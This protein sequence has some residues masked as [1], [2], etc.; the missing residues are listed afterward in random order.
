VETA[1]FTATALA[2]V[3]AAPASKDDPSPWR[4]DS[5]P[6]DFKPELFEKGLPLKQEKGAIHVL[7]WATVA[8][9]YWQYEETKAIVV[10][11]FARPTVND[12][13][14]WLLA[15]LHHNQDPKR[16]WSRPNREV[17]YPTPGPGQSP[18]IQTEASLW[19]YDIYTDLPT[20]EQVRGFLW[21]AGWGFGLGTQV[22]VSPD[23]GKTTKS[24]VI[25]SAGGVDPVA[26]RKV[27]DREVPPSLFPELRK[28]D[29]KK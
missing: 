20:D 7:A 4:A 9:N 28:P 5:P 17:I 24:T 8:D 26:W 29:K 23:T 3:L 13:D 21:E 1:V 18:P 19:S 11:R 25:L 15:I 10:K 12:A 22:S 27:F 6:T 14:R 16:P 2:L